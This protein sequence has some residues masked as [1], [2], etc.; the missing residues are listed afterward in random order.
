[1]MHDVPPTDP[2]ICDELHN[3][4]H[5]G[6]LHGNYGEKPMEGVYLYVWDSCPLHGGFEVAGG[7]REME[8]KVGPAYFDKYRNH[9]QM[10]RHWMFYEGQSADKGYRVGSE[11][12]WEPTYAVPNPFDG[13][14]ES[15]RYDPWVARV[16][17]DPKPRRK[18][19][20]DFRPVMSTPEPGE[21]VTPPVL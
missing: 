19:K 11:P 9:F 3:G 20:R 15:K 1:M 6:V 17:L 13:K 7:Y 14:I 16:N 2:C 10:H 12:P 4:K 18:P 8:A 5:L 21:P